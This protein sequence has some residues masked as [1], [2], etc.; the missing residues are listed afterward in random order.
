[1]LALEADHA[2][3]LD[4]D[5]GWLASRWAAFARSD[6]CVPGHEPPPNRIPGS[7]TFPGLLNGEAG[8]ALV[9]IGSAVLVATDAEHVVQ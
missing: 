5:E 1:M 9:I 7:D 4:E 2:C 3:H 8:A 6:L